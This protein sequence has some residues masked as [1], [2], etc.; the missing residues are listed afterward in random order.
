MTDRKDLLLQGETPEKP[1]FQRDESSLAEFTDKGTAY[2]ILKES[3][4]WKMLLN[5][6]IT[7]RKSLDRFLK[8]KTGQERHEVWGALKELDELIS[9]IEGR[10]K[11][12][13]D[14]AKQ[15]KALYNK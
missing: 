6:F 13:N 3:R 9:F 12:G 2:S 15:L 11:E 1:V 10:I 4:G 5:E 7:P 8:T 14:A